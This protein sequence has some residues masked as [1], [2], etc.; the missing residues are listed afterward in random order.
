MLI[1]DEL[2]KVDSEE[3]IV[4]KIKI[5]GKYS[6]LEDALR[7][8][9][10][11]IK[12]RRLSLHPPQIDQ[13][14]D[15][16]AKQFANEDRI[17]FFYDSRYRSGEMLDRLRNWFLPDKVLWPIAIQG[18]IAEYKLLKEELLPFYRDQQ[19]TYSDVKDRVS[20]LQANMQK[21][22]ISPA[23]LKVLRA[24]SHNAIYK[25]NKSLVWKLT[26]V[27]SEKKVN[28]L[29]SGSLE[30]IWQTFQK[31]I[32]KEKIWVVTKGLDQ[33]LPGIPQQTELKNETFPIGI[34]YIY[35]VAVK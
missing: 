2:L 22:I 20:Q 18:N 30:N 28:T 1:A 27:R 29:Q 8:Y 34:P 11:K 24:N 13:E 3:E 17:I 31:E 15:Y 7:F 9:R 25:Q 5:K 32:S 33:P 4:K 12:S 6:Q 35:V 21:W 10:P 16:F 19:A 26:R 14:I 23:P